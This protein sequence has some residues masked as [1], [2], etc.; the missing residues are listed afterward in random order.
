M[1]KVGFF[2]VALVLVMGQVGSLY[3]S[4]ISVDNTN[5]PVE[6][7]EAPSPEL[8][9]QT[10][11]NNTFGDGVINAAT[12][13]QKT[14]IFSTAGIPPAGAQVFP[15]LVAE[16]SGNA[17]N[18]TFGLWSAF[19]TTAT[20]SAVQ[21]FS[22]A[23]SPVKIAIIEWIGADSGTVTVGANVTNFN[24]IPYNFF[25]F[26]YGF[27]DP[28]AQTILYSYDGL[29]TPQKLGTA[30]I[31][32]YKTPS[33][34]A[35]AFGCDDLGVDK[36]YNDM[37]IKVESIHPAVPLPPSVLLMGSGLLGLVGLRRYRKS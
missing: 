30:A 18:Q 34:D 21:I 20:I 6:I 16:F 12:D 11:L 19:D 10:I 25:G 4:P 26:Y 1:K 28:A 13:Q 29:N 7:A 15:V 17:A 14:A 3:A 8:S 33:G 2:L 27:G 35:W 31:L 9:L 23:N 36:D 5:R 22:G 37:V 24:N 32:A